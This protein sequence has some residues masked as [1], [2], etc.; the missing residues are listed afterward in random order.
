MF[1]RE[2][3]GGDT[4]E[5]WYA[6]NIAAFDLAGAES[7]EVLGYG[8]GALPWSLVRTND[9]RDIRVIDEDL[10]PALLSLEGERQERR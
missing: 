10:E 7:I 6:K 3:S 4:A 2:I 9:G 5:T 1:D 8:S